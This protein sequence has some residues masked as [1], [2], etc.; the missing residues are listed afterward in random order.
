MKHDM[1]ET[2]TLGNEILGLRKTCHGNTIK[3][4]HTEK[5]TEWRE[6]ITEHKRECLEELCRRSTGQ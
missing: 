6:D 4:Q 5:V 3:Q 1:V 2:K